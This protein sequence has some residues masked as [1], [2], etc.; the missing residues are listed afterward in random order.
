[1]AIVQKCLMIIHYLIQHSL[2][3]SLNYAQY[4]STLM[5]H[6]NKENIIK[7]NL[8]LSFSWLTK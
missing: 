7:E 4:K 2:F 8:A 6:E 3:I 5:I 1:M